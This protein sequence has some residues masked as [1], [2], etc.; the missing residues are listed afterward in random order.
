MYD[1]TTFL[2]ELMHTLPYAI[3]F[4]YY[5]ISMFVGISIM[6]DNIGKSPLWKKSSI[7]Y[8]IWNWI[9]IVFLWVPF[10]FT[11]IRILMFLCS[12]KSQKHFISV[13]LSTFKKEAAL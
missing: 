11:P 2:G 12:R 1:T 4:I 9:L 6:E 10:F 13:L 5:I 8:R 7:M 3:G